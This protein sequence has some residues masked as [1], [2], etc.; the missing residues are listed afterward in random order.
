[1]TLT[2]KFSFSNLSNLFDADTDTVSA[3]REIEAA[4]IYQHKVETARAALEAA[5]PD[6]QRN[7]VRYLDC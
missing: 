5:L 4:R 2:G 6:P 3:A 7:W 1:M